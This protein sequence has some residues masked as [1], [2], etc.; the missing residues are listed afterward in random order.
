MTHNPIII[1][2]D[3]DNPAQA[4]ELIVKLGDAVDFYKIGMEL[5]AAAGI[6]FVREVVALGKQ[7]FLD[8]KMYD[9]SETVKRAVSVVSRSGA[10]FL[11]VHGHKSVMRAAVEGRGD[12]GLQILDV[13]VLTSFD[14]RDLDDDGRPMPVSDLVALRARN[15]AACGVDGLVCSPLDVAA[16]RAI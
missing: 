13:T 10:R 3:F 4:R 5:Y 1:A 9:I 16:V 7:V 6:D 14:Q 12:G 2:L 8:L 11:T 15:A